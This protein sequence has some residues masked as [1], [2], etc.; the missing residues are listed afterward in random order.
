VRLQITA[1]E[2][3]KSCVRWL[4]ADILSY[5]PFVGTINA[6]TNLHGCGKD[7]MVGFMSKGAPPFPDSSM[8]YMQGVASLLFLFYLLSN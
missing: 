7:N 6:W 8:R 1:D 5:L 4:V 3:R 2:A